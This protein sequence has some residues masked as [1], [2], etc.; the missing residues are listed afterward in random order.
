MSLASHTE[1][2]WAWTKSTSASG[3][4]V[5]TTT[6][7]TRV[8]KAKYSEKSLLK[9]SELERPLSLS[10]PGLTMRGSSA[11]WN[12][13][14]CFNFWTELDLVRNLQEQQG[15]SNTQFSSD[16]KDLLWFFRNITFNH[17][18]LG[19]STE[20]RLRGSLPNKKGPR[21]VQRPVLVTRETWL[22]APST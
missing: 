18:T 7:A 22:T 17:Q 19:D 20:R 6:K 5:F 10:A 12:V 14:K 4:G 11:E 9:W 21:W 3:T 13:V 15:K 8:R 16:R 2:F 1:Q